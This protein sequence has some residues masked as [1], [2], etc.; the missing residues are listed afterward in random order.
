MKTAATKVD[1]FLK[2]KHLAM[3]SEELEIFKQAL[4]RL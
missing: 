4:V 2:D 3:T 1:N